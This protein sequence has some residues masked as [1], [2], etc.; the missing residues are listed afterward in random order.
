[1]RSTAE[2]L[3]VSYKNLMQLCRICVTGVKVYTTCTRV[4][5]VYLIMMSFEYGFKLNITMCYTEGYVV[6]IRVPLPL[7]IALH[8]CVC[9]TTCGIV[10]HY[11]ALYTINWITLSLTCKI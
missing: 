6:V 3:G 9:Y 5:S 4:Y 8:V 1:M 10:L 11:T 2:G 7:H